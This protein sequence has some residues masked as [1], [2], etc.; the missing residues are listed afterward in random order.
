M[1]AAAAN[2]L[3]AVLSQIIGTI[4]G[5]ILILG[6]LLLKDR[7]AK[8][9]ALQRWKKETEETIKN[10]IWGL[11]SLVGNLIGLALWLVVTLFV[12]LGIVGLLVFGI[13]QL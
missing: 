7:L 10:L 3:V 4:I 11:L 12:V 5:L 9:P 6:P 2:S 8:I 13:R 1:E